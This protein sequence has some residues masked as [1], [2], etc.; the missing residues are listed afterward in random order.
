[1]RYVY[2]LNTER[3]SA[4][5]LQQASVSV[6]MRSARP[7]KAVYSPSHEVSVTR[8]DEQ[9][10]R[11]IWEAANVRPRGD[12]ELVFG[13]SPDPVGLH[14]LTQRSPAK[15]ATSCSWPPRPCAR[16]SAPWPRT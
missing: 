3:F 10:A 13:V 11:V 1:M 9:T 4:R 5:P 16:R 14:V 2:P 8:P 6:T 15:T 7:L 12:F